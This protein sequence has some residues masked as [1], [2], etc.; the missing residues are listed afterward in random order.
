MVA[1]VSLTPVFMLLPFSIHYQAMSET[2]RGALVCLSTAVPVL[3]RLTLDP[4]IIGSEGKHW[5]KK[6]SGRECLACVP[7]G[8]NAFK[9]VHLNI[10]SKKP[11]KSIGFRHGCDF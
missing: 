11:L 4:G 6:K 2:V 3:H 1:G 10:V 9:T 7:N 8:A 5:E